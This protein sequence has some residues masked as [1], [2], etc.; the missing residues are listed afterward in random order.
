MSFRPT[1]RKARE[2]ISLVFLFPMQYV[3]PED[4][5]GVETVFRIPGWMLQSH[6][7]QNGGSSAQPKDAEETSRQG[8]RSY[9]AE[10]AFSS[11][12]GLQS[13]IWPLL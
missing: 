8:S 4:L 6:C 10:F 12:G 13:L 11:K 9:I 2:L 1:V 5:V 3:D 7:V